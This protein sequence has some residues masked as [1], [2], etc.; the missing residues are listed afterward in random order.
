MTR[1]PVPPHTARAGRKD[2]QPGREVPR[3]QLAPSDAML[4]AIGPL[5]MPGPGEQWGRPPGQEDRPVLHGAADAVQGAPLSPPQGPAVSSAMMLG[6]D[7]A[8]GYAVPRELDGSRP[9]KPRKRP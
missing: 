8:G 6:V 5:T 1:N 7:S 2:A 3:P 9:K 4:T